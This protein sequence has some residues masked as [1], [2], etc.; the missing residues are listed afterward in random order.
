MSNFGV[1]STGFVLKRLPDIL[2]DLQAANRAVFG[3]DLDISANSVDGERIGIEAAQMTELWEIAQDIYN[4]MYPN[5][6]SGVGLDLA[7][8]A[9]SVKRREATKTTV[10]ASL[11]GT[12]GT[13]TGSGFQVATNT[14][15]IFE[16]DAPVSLTTDTYT[17]CPMSAIIAGREVVGIGDLQNIATPVS[18]IAA[19]TNLV[20]GIPG[21]DT[22]TDVDLQVRR[23]Q[24]VSSSFMSVDGKASRMLNEV[25]GITYCSVFEDTINHT[26]NFVVDGSASAQSIG[27][28][29][30]KIRTDGIA[31]TGSQSVTVVDVNGNSH[32]IK[33]SIP[34]SIPVYVSATVYKDPQIPFPSD[35][36]SLIKSNIVADS[37]ALIMGETVFVEKYKGSIYRVPGVGIV[38][39]SMTFNS[40]YVTDAVTTDLIM[41]YPS[42]RATFDIANITVTIV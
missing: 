2:A 10:I 32:T 27:N 18:G 11:S 34:V 37:I 21:L 31:T 33:Y 25:P 40:N 12:N 39:L 24:M 16:N 1:K 36:E 23:R 15:F 35:G 7:C 14:G 8:E 5:S 17:A 28:E 42:Y 26:V 22:E 29:I 9:S 20:P 38:T 19:V 3:N 13:S 6:A 4:D 30:W 41:P